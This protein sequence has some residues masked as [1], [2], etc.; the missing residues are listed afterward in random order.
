M[1][2][3]LLQDVRGI[4]RRMEIKNVSDGYARNFLIAK[5]LAIPAGDSALKLKQENDQEEQKLLDTYNKLARELPRAA[6]EIQIKIGKNGEVFGSVK[7]E[8]IKSAL[9]KKRLI[10]DDSEIILAKPLRVLGEH[11]VDVNLGRGIKGRVK[12]ILFPLRP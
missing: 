12:V 9:L 6:L 11:W 7:S 4:G 8:E 5:K 2:V 10:I 3:L 1:T